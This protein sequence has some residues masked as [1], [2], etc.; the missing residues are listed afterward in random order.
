V[1]KTIIAFS[2]LGLTFASC[3]KEEKVDNPF[4]A[5]YE[6]PFNVAPFEQ[7][8]AEHYMPGFNAGIEEQIKEIETIVTNSEVPSFENTIE[9]MDYSGTLLTK[10]SDVFFN[11][12][13]ANTDSALQA[14]AKDVKPMLSKHSDDI[15]LNEKLFARVKAV[16]E[17]KEELSLNTE[18]MML[19]DKTYKGFV[20]GGAN[21]P[22]DKK[23]AFRKINGELSVLTLKFGDNVLAETNNFK[24][25]I[26]N[27]EDLA[28][29]PESAI[30]GAEETAKEAGMEGKWIFTLQKPS[31]IPFLQYADKRELREKLYKGYVN[32]GNK[33]NEFDN[34]EIIQKIVSLR[35]ERANLLGYNTHADYILEKN[36][37]KT[38]ENVYKMLNKLWKPALKM[39][40]AEVKML[41]AMIKKEGGKFKLESWDWWYY[42]EKVRKAKYDLDENQLRPYFEL[43]NV[44]E[45][46][47]HVAKELFGI[48]FEEIKDIPKPHPDATAY[49]VKEANGNHIGVLY[50]DFHPRASKRG[51]AWMSSYIKQFKKDG[52]HVAPVIT[53][54]CNFSKPTGD[55]PALLSFDEVETL[56]HEFGHGLHG[57]LSNCTY[58]SLSGTSVSRDFVELPSQ[59]MENWASEPEVMKVYAKHYAT[60]E[61]IP[62]ELIEKIVKSGHFNQGFGTVEYLAASLLDM[63]YHT[64]T[65]AETIDPAKFEKEAMDKI[66]L[67]PEIYSRYRSTYFRHI[68][69]GGYSAGYYAYIWAAVLDADAFNAFKETS[70]FD[71][72]FAKA[73]RENILSRGGTDEPMKLY[74]T[75]R[76]QEPSIDPLL[77]RKGLK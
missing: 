1:K 61:V 53:N 33:G 12:L 57:L 70:L 58:F 48:T 68:F 8:K 16:Y 30:K 27:K 64:L 11:L 5:D 7:I 39:A 35:V 19:L 45:G 60:G 10:V 54:V 26:D 74:K 52:K 18:Q 65:T 6:T 76:G 2:I 47:F 22:A 56:F 20:R 49:Q 63:N 46:A 44:R 42:A 23:D 77:E 43:N 28:G 50:M 25:I 14:I 4:F 36:M 21:L 40:K 15:N 34:K 17:Q 38:S 13:S 69:A 29:L 59:V 41:Q 66:G 24:L 31:M 71:Q 62:D 55:K 37:A 73:F 67:I 51:G 9:A 72:K 32:R 3:Q 75:F